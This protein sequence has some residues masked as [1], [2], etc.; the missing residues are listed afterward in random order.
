MWATQ[1][2]H[3][4]GLHRVDLQSEVKLYDCKTAK[5]SVVSFLHVF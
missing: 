4:E 2:G 3:V 1:N 5:G